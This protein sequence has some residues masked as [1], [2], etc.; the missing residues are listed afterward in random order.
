VNS[1]IAADCHISRFQE[2]T[3]PLG[4]IAFKSTGSTEI[5]LQNVRLTAM[6]HIGMHFQMHT[7]NGNPIK[8][9]FMK[10][11]TAAIRPVKAKRQFCE[12]FDLSIMAGEKFD[13]VN[14]LLLLVF[15]NVDIIE[16][17]GLLVKQ[18]PAWN[19]VKI[20]NRWQSEIKI[21]S[22]LKFETALFD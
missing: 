16:S 14:T 22:C 11:H 13:H 5:D 4:K 6:F 21:R 15:P 1:V 12:L 2:H 17:I 18:V 20:P 7:Q 10:N 9:N 8:Q 3:V 19:P